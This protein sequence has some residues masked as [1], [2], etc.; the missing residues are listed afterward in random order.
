M[1][2]RKL[3]LGPGYVVPSSVM[4]TFHREATQ[5]SD[6]MVGVS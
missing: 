5:V 3:Q 1:E 4:P 2:Y 6:G